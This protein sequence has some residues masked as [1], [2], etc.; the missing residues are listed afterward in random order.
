VR[1]VISHAQHVTVKSVRFQSAQYDPATQTVIL[2][3]KQQN[4]NIAATPLQVQA[5]MTR[6]RP[7]HSLNVAQGLTDLQGNLINVD[8][9]PGK[10]VLVGKKAFGGSM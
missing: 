3:P 8:T 4:L 6:V 7:R 2:I 10:V 9:T 1:L 5:S